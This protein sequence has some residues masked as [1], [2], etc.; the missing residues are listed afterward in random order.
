M[1]NEMVPTHRLTELHDTTDQ[2]I[3]GIDFNG[4][5]DLFH[6]HYFSLHYCGD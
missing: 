3:I 5:S 2:G 1:G 4:S 6:D